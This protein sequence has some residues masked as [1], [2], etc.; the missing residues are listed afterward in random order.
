MIDLAVLIPLAVAAVSA[1]VG[2]MVVLRKQHNHELRLQQLQQENSDQHA[3][4]RA[5]VGELH[6]DVKGLLGH[7]RR[8]THGQYLS[9]NQHQDQ[10]ASDST[11]LLMVYLF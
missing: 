5:L 1:I 3:E 8:D 10:P 9:S 6:E 2:P 7:V 4:G 11:S